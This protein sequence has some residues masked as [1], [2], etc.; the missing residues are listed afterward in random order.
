MNAAYIYQK[1]PIVKRCTLLFT[2][3]LATT[4]F[5]ERDATHKLP[6]TPAMHTLGLIGGTSW[7]STVE[8][9]S[10]INQMVNDT[11]Q[12]NTNPPLILLNLNQHLVHALQSADRWDSIAGL[13]V[14]ATRRL[15]SSGA[16]AVL[17]CANTP[18]K[19]YEE[20]SKRVEIPI[21]HIA[22]ATGIE[23][24]RRGLH[25]VGLIGTIFTMEEDFIKKRLKEKFGV[26]VIVPVRSED[27]L[28]LHRIVQKELS[29]G[30]LKPETKTYILAQL[31]LLK[32]RGAQGII[33]GSTEFP[34]II[35][36]EDIDVPLFNTTLLHSQMA[37]K[38]I[39]GR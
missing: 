15:Q 28:E 4:G 27:R 12:N 2:L 32:R 36:A 31:D 21:L 22:D 5:Q 24:Q 14:D 19:V 20:V 37:V 11:F 38:F 16:E 26:D 9:Y 25:R 29:L 17:F 33:L 30:V 13:L 18:H 6:P 8:Y 3:I 1:S 35:R 39:S 7:H 23:I 34:L 10:Y